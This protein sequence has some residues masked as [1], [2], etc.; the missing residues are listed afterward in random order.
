[1]IRL[2]E[3]QCRAWNRIG[4]VLIPGGEGLPSFSDS[5]VVHYVG[6]ALESTPPDDREALLTLVSV[7]AWLP[8]PLL[9][10]MLAANT[11]LRRL[12]G[13]MGAPFRLLDMGLRGVVFTVYYAGVDQQG[14]IHEGIDCHIHCEPVS[15]EDP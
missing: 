10:L 12:P 7:L 11:P 8:R 4:D 15:R 3:R 14:R 6:T 9:A 5:G 13:I 2:T 1:M